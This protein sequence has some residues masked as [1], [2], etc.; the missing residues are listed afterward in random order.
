MSPRKRS[1]QPRKSGQTGRP[2]KCTPE[3]TER[4]CTDVRAGNFL[5]TAAISAGI[6]ESTL[7]RWR[8]WGA[9]HRE[10]YA[11]FCKAIKRA[12]ADAEKDLVAEVR[13]GEQFV[14]VAAAALLERRF[15][16]RWSRGE[17]D[18]DLRAAQA[19]AE[20]DAKKAT[21]ERQKLE[22]E[23]LAARAEQLKGGNGDLH[24]HLHP[25]SKEFGDY[26][27]Q[28]WGFP[29]SRLIEGAT[30]VTPHEGKPETEGE[31][32]SGGE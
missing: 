11:S 12:E 16:K 27:K 5:E 13:R 19:Q 26:V 20:I 21:V 10:P 14:W 9:D 28:T 22:T 24:L 7:Y 4:I 17:L 15:R 32:T 30:E 31:P 2:S 3:L 1:S 29:R 18:Y 23:I 8:K 25:D 6:D